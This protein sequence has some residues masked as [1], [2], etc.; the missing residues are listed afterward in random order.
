MI[1][2]AFTDARLVN[3]AITMD[4]RGLNDRSRF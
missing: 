4:Y 3:R 2:R 1:W